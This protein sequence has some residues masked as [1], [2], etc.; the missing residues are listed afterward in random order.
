M[1]T[2]KRL[3]LNVFLSVR[4]DHYESIMFVVMMNQF[5]LSFLVPT[6]IELGAEGKIIQQPRY[7]CHAR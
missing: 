7:V 4:T 5:F 6:V 3:Y 1:Y 2:E